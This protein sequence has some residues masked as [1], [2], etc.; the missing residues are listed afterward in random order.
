MGATVFQRAPP[1]Q[2]DEGPGPCRGHRSSGDACRGPR[3]PTVP[4]CD[5]VSASHV[6]R[7]L[8]PSHGREGRLQGTRGLVRAEWVQCPGGK[9]HI[10]GAP[11]TLEDKP[12]TWRGAPVLPGAG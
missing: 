3:A 1:E 8:S 2:A 7:A 12:D 6:L 5:G 4:S 9:C 10:R 11:G